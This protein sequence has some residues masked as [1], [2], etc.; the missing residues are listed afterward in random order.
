MGLIISP[1]EYQSIILDR[2]EG[3]KYIGIAAGYADFQKERITRLVEIPV[4]TV[5]EGGMFSKQTVAKPGK[6]DLTLRLGPH[7]IE[8]GTGE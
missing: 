5:K 8:T 7:Q 6:L 2:A 3:A 1:G 4:M